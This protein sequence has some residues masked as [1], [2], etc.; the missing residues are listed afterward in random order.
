[1]KGLLVCV[2]AVSIV[3]SSGFNPVWRR[4]KSGT[5]RSAEPNRLLEIQTLANTFWALRHGQSEANV[6][7][8]IASNPDVACTKYGLSEVGWKQAGQAGKDVVDEYGSSSCAG[9]AIVSSDLLRARETAQAVQ[10]QILENDVPLYNSQVNLDVRLRERSF[11]DWDET[12]HDNYH[13]VWQDDTMDPSHT[14]H[15][16]ESVHSVMER[17]TSCVLEWDERLE[18][19]MIVCVAH[20]DVLQILQTAFE[21]K[22]GS[23]HRSL[24][25][26]ETAKL[27]RLNLK[28]D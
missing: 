26:L 19:H 22:D 9:V 8:R 13:K 18:N 20:G 23:L 28:I 21:K 6:Q 25:H 1:M 10:T 15:G 12:S 27:R 3:E 16:V 17:A 7:K 2:A 24:P 11:G 14:N 4:R 5:C